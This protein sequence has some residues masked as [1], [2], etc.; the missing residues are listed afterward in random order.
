MTFDHDEFGRATI[1]SQPRLVYGVDESL[2]IQRLRTGDAAAFETL[3]D[4]YSND[5]YALLYRMTENAEE[6][7][8]LTQDTFLRALRSVK[9]FRGDSELKTWLYRIAINESR[10]R[11][12]WWKRR[13]RDL[14]LSIDATIG[15]TDRTLADT[16][17]DRSISP[18]ESA[19]SREREYALK[20]ALAELPAVYREAI[21]LCD[22]EGLSYDETAA[23]L[24]IGIGTVKSR[25]SRGR[26]EL[27]RRLKDF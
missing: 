1:P 14:T 27:R 4:R 9:G 23:A 8:D 22:I 15:D 13:R 10:N 25:I 5:I 26:Q 16:L 17:V 24:S 3:I 2:F 21:V 11:F 19:L 20:A 7:S 6:A 12:R 18:E